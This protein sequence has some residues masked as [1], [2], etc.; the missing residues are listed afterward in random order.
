[1][2]TSITLFVRSATACLLIALSGCMAIPMVVGSKMSGPSAQTVVVSG[3]KFPDDLFRASAIQGGGV[4]TESTASYAK[5]EFRLTGVRIE[6]QEVKHGEY[7]L[8]G[9][10]SKSGWRLPSF[11]N[12]VTETL[13]KVKDYLAGNGFKVIGDGK[14]GL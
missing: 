6:L 13:E 3:P 4:V 7:Q 11:S 10:S 5:S 2:T 9:S 14:N 1:M 12:P 8:I